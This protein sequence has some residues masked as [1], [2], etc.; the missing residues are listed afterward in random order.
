[1]TPPYGLCLL[2]SAAIGGLNVAQVMR[3]VTI[4][5]IPMLIIL[6]LLILFPDI[7]LWLPK[8]LLPGSFR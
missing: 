3:D 1:M 6:M 8:T 2:I 7:I 5:L 4:I